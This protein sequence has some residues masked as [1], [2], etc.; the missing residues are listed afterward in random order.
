MLMGPCKEIECWCFELIKPKL[1]GKNKSIANLLSRYYSVLF[2]S[3]VMSPTFF[4]SFLRFL[5]VWKIVY[6]YF[7]IWEPDF[8]GRLARFFPRSRHFCLSHYFFLVCRNKNQLRDFMTTEPARL[9]GILASVLIKNYPVD[10][11]NRPSD[12]GPEVLLFTFSRFQ[13]IIQ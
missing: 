12:N 11:V 2:W 9:A 4:G 3:T 7:A 6:L 5:Q 10:N 1:Y 13:N 8:M